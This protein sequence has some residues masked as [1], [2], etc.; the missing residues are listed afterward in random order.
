MN[1]YIKNTNFKFEPLK[2]ISNIKIN[3][4]F[5]FEL[6]QC[7]RRAAHYR[8]PTL[9]PGQTTS[10]VI[11]TEHQFFHP[12]DSMNLHFIPIRCGGSF[13]KG[14]KVPALLSHTP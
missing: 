10:P 13:L 6:P 2:F 12:P 9:S 7:R 8:R 11:R 14:C 3:T 1:K 4:R 5:L